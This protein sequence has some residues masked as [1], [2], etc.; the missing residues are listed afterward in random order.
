MRLHALS[1]LANG[2]WGWVQTANFLLCG[3]L[4]LAGALGVRRALGGERAGLWG[5]ILLAL[6]GVG[7]LGA[8]LFPADPGAGFPP[9]APDPTSMSR[10]GLLHFVFGGIGFYAL[11][12]ACM[13]FARRFAGQG[14]RGMAALSI[15]T[16]VGFLV[17]F[18]AIAS[19]SISPTT[20]LTFYAA[21]AWIWVWH[22][23]VLGDVARGG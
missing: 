22:T 21:V 23:L 19:G 17:S 6:Y 10:A 5:P 16:G 3:A 13:V 11:V 9:G 18:G 7:L 14:R 12:G 1:L 4:V 2:A 15:A 20:M 8:G